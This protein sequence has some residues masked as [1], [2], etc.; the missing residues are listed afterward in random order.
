MR[1]TALSLGRA[2]LGG[3]AAVLAWAGP[4]LASVPVPEPASL[5]LLATGIAAVALGARWF[6]RK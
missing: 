3:A 6:R 2:A 4:A 5:T 1:S